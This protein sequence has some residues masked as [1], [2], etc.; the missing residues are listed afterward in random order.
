MANIIV[1]GA[2]WGDEGKGKIVDL[3]TGHFDIVAR[4]QGGHNAGHTVIIQGKKN[5]LHLIP[6]GILRPDKACVI[7][8]GVVIDLSAL[9]SEIEHLESVGIQ[10]RGRLFI[11]DRAHVI[12]DYHRALEMADE[13]R[14]GDDRIGT[15]SRGIGPAYEDKAGRRGLRI[16]DLMNPASVR[17][18]LQANLAGRQ[19]LMPDAGLD[20]DGICKR[21]LALGGELSHYFTDVSTYLNRAMD[22]GKWVLFEGA[23]GTMLDVDHGTYPFVTASNATAGGACTGTGVGPTRIDGVVGIAKAYTTRVGKGPFPTELLDPL[24]EEIRARG[25]EFGASTGR[26][27]RCG[28]FDSV[29]VRHSCLVNNLDTLVITKL[30]VLDGF[31]EIRVC[32][33]YRHKGRILDSFP[34]DLQVLTE[35][36]PEYETVPGWNQPTA[37]ICDLGNLPVLARDYLNRLSD[38]VRAEISLVSTGP[39]RAQTIV[40]SPHSMLNSVL[41]SR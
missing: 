34:P 29:V 21:T 4:Y 30:D 39:D 6:S 19:S 10:C 35:C 5:V 37:G 13:E 33:G 24:G 11:S 40:T 28:W 26:P 16:C 41:T 22:E 23:Q 38:L 8:N 36:Q 12:L 9:K 3:L 31:S 27:R 15:T 7:G 18:I 2:Q 32:T 25:V 1:V 14:R 17:R 20:I